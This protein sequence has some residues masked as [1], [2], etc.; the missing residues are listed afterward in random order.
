MRR[1]IT[2]DAVP[3]MV[4]HA[5][6][7]L[8]DGD[9]QFAG[10]HVLTEADLAMLRESPGI[11]IEVED[12]LSVYARDRP[13]FPAAAEAATLQALNGL[14]MLHPGLDQPVAFQ[15]LEKLLATIAVMVE[16]AYE[17]RRGRWTLPAPTACRATT[18]SIP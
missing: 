18:T 12:A 7:T 17:S 16:A 8:P 5:P 9:P 1:I 14:I 4:L 13:I 6:L 15:A 10:G 11:E 2:F 3:G